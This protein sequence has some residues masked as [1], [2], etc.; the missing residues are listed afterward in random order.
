MHHLT[1]NGTIYRLIQDRGF[2]FI[3]GED[4]RSRFFHC[5]DV[6]GSFDTLREGQRVEFLSVEDEQHE[7]KLRAKLVK[8]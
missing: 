3:L 7:G 1:T 2:G 4:K 8:P 5:K 6:E